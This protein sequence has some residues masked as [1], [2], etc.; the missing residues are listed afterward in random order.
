MS[1]L[2]AGM[3]ER[4]RCAGS[5]PGAPR[6]DRGRRGR[7]RRAGRTTSAPAAARR[8]PR[9][10]GPLSGALFGYGGAGDAGGGT[11]HVPRAAAPS[12]G[13][14]GQLPRGHP[15]VGGDGSPHRDLGVQPCGGA[16]RVAARRAGGPHGAGRLGELRD[17]LRGGVHAGLPRTPLGC[18][19]LGQPD[20]P[21]FLQGA[22]EHSRDCGRPS[23]LHRAPCRRGGAGVL[24]APSRAAHARGALGALGEARAEEQ[25]GGTHRRA[26]D[27]HLVHLPEEP[28]L[29]QGQAYLHTCLLACPPCYLFQ[30]C[31]SR[32]AEKR[33]ALLEASGHGTLLVQA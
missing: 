26:H 19:R 25:L 9:A 14:P 23:V 28:H 1:R 30:E 20:L 17:L 10:P 12:L 13:V 29:R 4:G 16:L 33:G 24:L 8:G 27:G 18:R 6:R 11:Q 7:G 21:R 2:R 32:L 22:A 15:V 31:L 3:H 5:A